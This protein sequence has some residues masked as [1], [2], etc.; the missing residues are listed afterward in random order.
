MLHS[1]IR[2]SAMLAGAAAAFAA[3]AALAYDYTDEA[4]VVSSTPI[5]ERVNTPT[6]Q[7]WN[8]RV[9]TQDYRGGD[10]GYGGAILGGIIG[11]VAGHQVGSGR[12]NDVATAGGAAV[13]ALVGNE[14]ENRNRPGYAAPVEQTVQRC[15]TVDNYRDEI[16]GYDVVYLYN[17]NSVHTRLPYDPGPTVRVNVGM[18]R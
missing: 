4:P 12:G 17:G 7:C 13:G 8:E 14:L 16:R 5:V 10:H 18:V 3:G 9:T 6:Q 11:G 15:S 1:H 2:K